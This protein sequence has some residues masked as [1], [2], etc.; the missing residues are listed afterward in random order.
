MLFYISKIIH[1]ATNN[2][3]LNV[4]PLTFETS[5]PPSI[6]L[7]HFRFCHICLSSVP[8]CR[9]ALLIILKSFMLVWQSIARAERGTSFL[10]LEHKHRL[11]RL[12][13]RQLTAWIEVCAL[14]ERLIG[15]NGGFA[16]R[17]GKGV[18]LSNRFSS[19]KERRGASST[20]LNYAVK[21]S[22]AHQLN[23]LTIILIS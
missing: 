6:T 14:E 17:N 18:V 5:I 7:C 10:G 4:L 9:E 19:W 11:W 2:I 1:L 13:L 12:M 15:L 20:R 22:L 16:L 3:T 21:W 23:D 8:D